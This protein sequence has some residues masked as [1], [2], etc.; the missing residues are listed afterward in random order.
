MTINCDVSAYL[1][2][3]KEIN[4]NLKVCNSADNAYHNN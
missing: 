2:D 4:S 3:T 1:L